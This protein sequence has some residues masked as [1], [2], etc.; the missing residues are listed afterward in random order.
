MSPTAGSQARPGLA[1]NTLW[2]WAAAAA[3]I[4]MAVFVS[5]LMIRHLG[6]E[7]YGLWALV[8]SVVEYYV[9]LDFGIRSALVK[10]VAQHWALEEWDDLNRTLNTGLAFLVVMATLLLILTV[11]IGPFASSLFDITPDLRGTFVYMVLITGITWAISIVFLCFSACLEAVQRFDLSNRIF[12][13]CNVGRVVVTVVLLESGFG[14]SSVVTAVVAARLIQCGLLW[15]TFNRHFPQF[16]WSFQSVD[17][18]SFGK[19][20]EFGLH[21]VPWMIGSLVL[22]QGPAVVIGRALP[23]QFV[24]YYSLP[25]RL[26]QNVVEF[27]YRLG[28]VT[29]ARATELVAHRRRDALIRL[30]IQ[31][32][33]YALVAFMPAAIFLGVYGDAVF[34][35]WLTPRFAAMSA[36]LIPLFILS[37]IFADAAQFTSQ[38]VLYSLAKHRVLAWSLLAES[39]ITISLVFHFASRGDLWHAA[40]SAAILSLLNRGLMTPF[41]LCRQLEY[42]L[43]RYIGQ[44]LFRPIS[45]GAMAAAVLWLLRRTWLPGENYLELGAAGVIGSVLFCVLAGRYC[46]PTEHQRLALAVIR[47]RAPA[48]E[49]PARHWFG[50][51]PFDMD[52]EATL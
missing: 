10:Y 12:I 44:I 50:V 20:A 19:L 4:G 41:L 16:R 40:L 1:T 26:I 45:A 2:S 49:A 27:V 38:A 39:I 15:R 36:P 8:F 24:G 43:W 21:N 18:A 5:P 7:Q 28:F 23:E 22:T 13:G 33:R 31:A 42:P 17:R 32:N 46:L 35:H 30:S 48:F 11:S 47:Q 52:G 3:N 37:T 34:R 25:G 6:D 29:N 9:L 14:L 51:G